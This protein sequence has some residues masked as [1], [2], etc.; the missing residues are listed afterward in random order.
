MGGGGAVLN[1]AAFIDDNYPAR[2]LSGDGKAAQGEKVRHD[3]A[4]EAYKAGYA[5]YTRDCTKLLDWIAT[6]A[7]IKEQGKQNFTN[8]NYVF[9]LYNQTHPDRQIVPPKEPKFS[10]FYQ[11]SEQQ[12][13]GEL[14]FAVAGVLALGYATFRFLSTFHF[15]NI[16]WG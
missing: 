9:K 3:K 2:P 11:P 15:N 14:I 16:Q 1:S 6:N 8:D 12:K 7:Q 10:N 5:K 13:Q 4:L